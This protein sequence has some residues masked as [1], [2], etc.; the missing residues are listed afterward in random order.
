LK[1]AIIQKLLV[2]DREILRRIF[3]PTKGNQ[4]WRVQTNEELDKLI[5]HKNIINYI[6]AQRLSCFGHVQRMP[7]TRTAKKIFNWKPLTKKS[8]G[9]T[10]GGIAS[11]RT[12]AK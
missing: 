6:K 1:D 7:D 8:Q 5:K 10:D 12:S 11:D 4:I 9:S 3:G 2:F